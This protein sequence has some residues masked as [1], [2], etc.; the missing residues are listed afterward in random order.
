MCGRREEIQPKQVELQRGIRVYKEH[1]FTVVCDQHLAEGR[2]L[3]R[4]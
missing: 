3:E 1:A 2:R 4:L